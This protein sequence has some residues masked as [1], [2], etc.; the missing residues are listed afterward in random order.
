MRL[1]WDFTPQALCFLHASRVLD[2]SP[3]AVLTT[4]HPHTDPQTAL[5]SN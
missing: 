4:N 2:E 5:T 3:Q 1:S